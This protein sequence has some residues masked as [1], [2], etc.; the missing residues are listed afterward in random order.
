M[1]QSNTT[2][3]KLNNTMERLIDKLDKKG[4]KGGQKSK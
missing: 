1:K 2:M 4:N 3:G